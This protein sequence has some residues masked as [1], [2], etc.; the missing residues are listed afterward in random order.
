MSCTHARTYCTACMYS[1]YIKKCFWMKSEW[2]GIYRVLS[3]Q[4][5]IRIHLLPLFF[6]EGRRFAFRTAAI[7]ANSSLLRL[8][9][10]VRSPFFSKPTVTRWD[11]SINII[12]IIAVFTL[13]LRRFRGGIIWNKVPCS[14]SSSYVGEGSAY[15]R[16][17][18]IIMSYYSRAYNIRFDNS[19]YFPTRQVDLCTF[20]KDSTFILWLKFTHKN[21]CLL[22][23]PSYYC[24][25]LVSNSR[26]LFSGW[27]N[28]SDSV[29][30][31]DILTAIRVGT[32]G[33]CPCRL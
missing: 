9:S 4:H 27:L 2:G 12:I 1:Y 17:V 10:S 22:V 18:R 25:Y 28:V 15:G 26:A 16:H 31:G 24:T 3:V 20:S 8:S 11:S 29:L 33:W 23:P 21:S 6:N 32:A 19:S 5:A 30:L 7:T 14:N 13:F